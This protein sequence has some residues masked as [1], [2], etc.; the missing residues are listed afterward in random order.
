MSKLIEEYRKRTD[1]L[2]ISSAPKDGTPVL[3]TAFEVDGSL[4]EIHPMR[5]CHIQR[6]G[7]FPGAT[8]MW[9]ALSGEYTWNDDGMGGG[10]THWLPAY[11][12]PTPEERAQQ[13]GDD[14]A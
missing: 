12:D 4:F 9:T 5:W 6:N 7:L 14:H 13:G 11:R 2:P 10:P 3:L 1:W 8:G